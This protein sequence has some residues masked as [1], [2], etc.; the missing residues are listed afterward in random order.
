[1]SS[2]R[3]NSNGTTYIEICEDVIA[4]WESIFKIQLEDDKKMITPETCED[5]EKNEDACDACE[6]YN[7]CWG[8][9]PWTESR[10]EY[11]RSR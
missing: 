9:S 6:H 1:M 8:E 4:T 3:K 10:R 5:F 11:D 2:Y 7:V